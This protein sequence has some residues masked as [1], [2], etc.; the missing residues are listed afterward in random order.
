V[1]YFLDTLYYK[2][3]LSSVQD[4][5]TFDGIDLTGSSLLPEKYSMAI[6]YKMLS[7]MIDSFKVDYETELARLRGGLT[8]GLEDTMRYN[9]GGID[10]PSIGHLIS[11]FSN[12]ITT[13]Y[14]PPEQIMF[15]I[16]DANAHSHDLTDAINMEKNDV[17]ANL[18]GDLLD[19]G[20]YLIRSDVA[21]FNINYDIEITL[22]PASD[23]EVFDFIKT[24][25]SDFEYEIDILPQKSGGFADHDIRVIITKVA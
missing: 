25:I 1:Y 24:R 7:M 11:G 12:S 14:T 21:I 16:I 23:S 5:G 15:T 10:E 6:I 9:F 22:L 18:K 2:P 3:S 19:N 8:E 20:K 17:G 4:W 13:S